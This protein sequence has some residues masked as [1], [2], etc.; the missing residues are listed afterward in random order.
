M[1]KRIAR[2]DKTWL[3]SLAEEEPARIFED[4]CEGIPEIQLRPERDPPPVVLSR[5]W[6]T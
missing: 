2:G 1:A 5:I 4:L 3:R 6:R